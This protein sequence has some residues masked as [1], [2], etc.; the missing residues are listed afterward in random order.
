ML[1]HQGSLLLRSGRPEPAGDDRGEAGGIERAFVFAGAAGLVLVYALRGGGSYDT[2]VFEEHGLVIW[3]VLAVGVALGLLPRSRP[4]RSVLLLLGALGAYAGWTALSLSWTDSSELTFTELA[5]ALDYLGLAVLLSAVFTRDNWR[6]AAA[7]LGFGALLVCVVAVGSRL[8]PSVFGVDHVD[9]ALHID[10]L[11]RPFGYWNAVGAWGAMCTAIGLA[12]SAHDPSRFRRAV[13][14]SLVPVA[15]LTT[16]LTYSRA[17]AGGTALAVLAV[18]VLSRN[19][20]TVLVHAAIAAAGQRLRS[21]LYG[22]STRSRTPRDTR[23]GN[24]LRG[25]SDRGRCLRGCGSADRRGG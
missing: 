7:G 12:W 18:L 25:A 23:G 14:L 15:A 4:S 9:H 22:A 1:A 19:R 2:V 21:L 3:W 5:R 8:A 11:S 13:A 24:R 6:H 20:V 16:Y 10:R 17:G